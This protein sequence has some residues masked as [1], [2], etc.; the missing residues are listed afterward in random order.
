MDIEKLVAGLGVP[1]KKKK[2]AKIVKVMAKK[3]FPPKPAK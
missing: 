2:G 1:A 3:P